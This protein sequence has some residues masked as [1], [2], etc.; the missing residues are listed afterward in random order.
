MG[1]QWCQFLV[2]IVLLLLGI[3]GILLLVIPMEDMKEPPD[4]MYGIVLDAGSSHTAMYIYKWPAD[5]QN[6]TGIVTQH[7]ECHVKGGGISSY[8]GEPG[9]A[10]G[11]LEVCLNQAVRDIPQSRH[12]LSPVYLGATAGMRLLNMSSPM[13]S[14]KILLEVK[15]KI[16]SYPFNF[17]G[18]SILTGQEEGAYGWVTVNYLLE[19]FAKYGFIGRW[20]NPG[21]GTVGAL[22]LGGAS[23]QIT[24]A[25][26]DTVEDKRNNM[27]LRLYGQDYILYTHSFLCYGQDQVL[28]RVLARLLKSQGYS[29]FI[30]HPCYPA[31]YNASVNLGDVFDS[32]CTVKDKPQAYNPYR[33]V[34]VQGLGEYQHCLANVSNILSFSECRFSKCSFDGIFQPNV[35][36]SYMAF[37]GFYY[38]YSFLQHATG[39]TASTPAFLKGAAQTVCNMTFNDMLAKAP[40]LNKR[41]HN[42]CTAS[43]YIQVLML[44]GYGFDERSFPRVSFQKKVGDAS[45]GWALGYMLSL[46]SFLPAESLGI[47]KALRP[48]AWACLLVLF[49][50]LL[51]LI[52]GYLLMQ[53]SRRKKGSA[54]II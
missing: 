22:D 1:K 6:G 30:Y 43:V 15:S 31:D 7:G 32:P 53:V 41:L 18:A 20:L 51:F 50:L 25:T 24:F 39:I 52:L 4:Y 28:L 8:A 45:I 42:Y 54:D 21:K 38:T 29:D 26:Q 2:P 27:K 49:A 47:R 9:G 34:M 40:G 46:S 44:E 13:E 5:K 14:E 16:K 33:R 48:E 17:Q 11:S 36:G 23:T 10:G 37:A 12:R 3:L 19:N 35:T